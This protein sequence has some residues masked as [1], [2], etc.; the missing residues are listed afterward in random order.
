MSELT[1]ASLKHRALNAGLWSLAGFAL[2]MIIR[3]GSNLAMTRLLMP[4]S[5]GVMSIATTV[6]VGLAMFS[7]LGLKQFIVQS[8]RGSD[9]SYLNTAWAIQILRGAL[10]W[11]ISVAVSLVV[12]ALARAGLISEGSVYA[13]PMLPPV[14]VVLCVST[15]ISGF[16][17]TRLLE[18]SRSLSL[19]P[20]TLIE[21]VG[22]IVG[23]ACMIAWVWIDRSI[24]ALVAGSIAGTVARTWL[25]HVWLP[26][27]RN[28]WEWDRSAAHEILHFGKWIFLASILG[29]LVNAGDQLLLGGMVNSTVLGLYVIASLYVSAVDG[30]LSKL[31]GDVSFPAFSEV[32]RERPEHLKQHYYQFHRIIA[33]IAYCSSG[34]LMAFGQALIGLLYDGRYEAAGHILAIIAATLLTAPFRLATQ[35]FLALGMPKLQSD[36][37]LV[38]LISLIVFTPIGFHLAGL[39]GALAGI[40][41][42]HFSYVPIIISYN[43]KHKLFDLRKEILF[44]VLAPIGY[45]V[46]ILLSTVVGHLR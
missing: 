8:N 46:G 44:S 22:Q 36:V 39:T 25:S 11:A 16:S 33:A 41:F 12:L 26:G 3:F 42:S 2:S 10:L 37:V 17:S 32:V 35:S 27:L 6:M 43:V 7:D 23:L 21:I 13:S 1:Q 29:F 45:A 19:G 20:L 15:V 31:M 28:R 24:W 5:F 4:E 30:I 38:R 18:A 34:F 14:I 40:V 9:P